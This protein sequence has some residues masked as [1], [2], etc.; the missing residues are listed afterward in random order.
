[1]V[2]TARVKEVKDA[3]RELHLPEVPAPD[4]TGAHYR[5]NPCTT[6]RISLVQ[7][8]G[9]GVRG[10]DAH[11]IDTGKSK[12]REGSCEKN[13]HKGETDKTYGLIDLLCIHGFCLSECSVCVR[14]ESRAIHDDM[15]RRPPLH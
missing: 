6:G 14:L 11:K 13:Y 8:N 9:A 5:C 1:M 3:R 10:W 2:A 12:P 7:E 15:C 4:T